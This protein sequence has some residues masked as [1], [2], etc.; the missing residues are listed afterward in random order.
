MEE[1]NGQKKSILAFNFG[2]EI[3]VLW[4]YGVWIYGSKRSKNYDSTRLDLFSVGFEL[5]D[6]DLRSF[7]Y[8]FTGGDSRDFHHI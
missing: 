4:I 7:W 5:S 8:R 2:E 1:T 6:V 3:R